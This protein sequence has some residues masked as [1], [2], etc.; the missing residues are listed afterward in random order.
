MARQTMDSFFQADWLSSSQC[1]QKVHVRV[2]A[3]LC[4]N[5]LDLPAVLRQKVPRAAELVTGG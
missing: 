1:M 2:N 4:C 3:V 5:A